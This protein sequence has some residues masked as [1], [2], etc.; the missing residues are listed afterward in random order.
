MGTAPKTKETNASVKKF[1]DAVPDARKRI[2]ARA[3]NALMKK[4]TKEKPKMWGPSIVGY[5]RYRLVYSNGMEADWPLAAFSPRKPNLTIYLLPEFKDRDA[6]MERLGPHKN[7][8]SCLYIKSLRE[9]DMKILEQLIRSS[10]INT[11]KIMKKRAQ[12]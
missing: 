5:G 8:K 11:K 6:L 9:I 4:I 10:L 7:G 2:D 12:R 3:I 1:I